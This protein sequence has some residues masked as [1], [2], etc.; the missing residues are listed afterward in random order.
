MYQQ[1]LALVRLYAFGS[2]L[3]VLIAIGSSL[4]RTIMHFTL[5]VFLPFIP[6]S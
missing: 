3:A 1:R 6:L 4:L 5:K 2:V